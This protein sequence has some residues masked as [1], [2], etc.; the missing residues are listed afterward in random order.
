VRTKLLLFIL[1]FSIGSISFKYPLNNRL[2]SSKQI[3]SE[4]VYYKNGTLYINGFSGEGE[5]SIYSIIGNKLFSTKISKLESSKID[6]NLQNGNM[7]IIQVRFS[8]KVKIFKIVA[9]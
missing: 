3:N 1:L 7:Y 4:Q 6:I 5:I 9:S 2:I 8:N